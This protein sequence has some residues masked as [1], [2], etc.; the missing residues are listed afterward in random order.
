MNPNSA[1]DA[2]PRKLTIEVTIMIVI[3]VTDIVTPLAADLLGFGMVCLDADAVVGAAFAS[4]LF[5]SINFGLYLLYIYKITPQAILS[6]S[7]SMLARL[8]RVGVNYI[9]GYASAILVPYR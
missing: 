4:C 1:C 2:N 8:Q 7:E 6:S 9:T 5:M 3:A